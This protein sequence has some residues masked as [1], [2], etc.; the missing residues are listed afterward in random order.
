MNFLAVISL[1]GLLIV[2][3]VEIPRARFARVAL[4]ACVA[5]AAL[6]ACVARPAT[7]A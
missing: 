3:S 4:V 7:V 6:V 5:L 1:V 2:A